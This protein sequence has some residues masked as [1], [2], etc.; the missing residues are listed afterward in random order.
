MQNVLNHVSDRSSRLTGKRGSSSNSGLLLAEKRKKK[1]QRSV[2]GSYYTNLRHSW[3]ICFVY[4]C[5]SWSDLVWYSGLRPKFSVT[6]RFA[7]WL[8]LRP[9]FWSQTIPQNDMGVLTVLR[10]R[11]GRQKCHEGAISIVTVRVLWADKSSPRLNRTNSR[12]VWR[13][14]N[15]N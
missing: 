2:H 3:R 1:S 15:W 6:S 7:Y 11:R 8:G 12:C 13:D 14:N 4:I 5:E 9:N 10:S